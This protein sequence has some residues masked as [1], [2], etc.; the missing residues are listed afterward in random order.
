MI[1][2]SCLASQ[3]SYPGGSHCISLQ[4]S[5]KAATVL[6]GTYENGPLFA[7]VSHE[8]HQGKGALLRIEGFKIKTQD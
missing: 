8:T 4:P 2:V 6:S 3:R 5:C 1:Y 7:S